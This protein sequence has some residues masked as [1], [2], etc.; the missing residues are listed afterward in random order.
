VRA[1]VFQG[2]GQPLA[3]EQV[4]D[5]TP[6][7]GELV[8]RVRACGICGTDLHMSR[9]ALP[10]GLV[11]GHEFA[12]EIA[13]LGRDAAAHWK[14]GERVCALPV[15]GCA[16]CLPCLAGEPQYCAQMRATGLGPV[17]GAY[18]EYV[19]VGAAESLR[20]PEALSD[21][22]GALIEPLAVGLH[23]LRAAELRPGDDVLVLGAGPVGIA[24]LLWARHLGARR[25]AV[26]DPLEPRRALAQR[27]GAELT[28]DPGAEEVGAALSRH[29]S[30]AP[31]VIL[32]CVGAPGLLQQTFALAPV[33]GRIVVVGVC[34][35]PD[36][37]ETGVALTKDLS[38]RFVSYYSRGDF[39][40]ALAM[41]EARRLDPS[42]MVSEVIGLDQ[43]PATFEAL[44]HPTDQCKVIVAP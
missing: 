34:L 31:E 42:P 3:I 7:P 24:A 4:S 5:P 38:L 35:K 6:G 37:L 26:S 39:A 41:L 33:R 27:C 36:P 19:L 8:L 16:A 25:V 32:E 15:I 1:A 22:Q 43:L 40:Y 12:G 29:W 14:L 11:M 28:L 2:P 23:A 44:H 18:A 20:L 21:V 30:G 9:L 13:A 17:G 10:R